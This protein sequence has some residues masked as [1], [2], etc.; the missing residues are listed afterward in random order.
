MYDL[1]SGEQGIENAVISIS[2]IDKTVTTAH[3][4]DF[5]RLL[6]PGVYDITATADG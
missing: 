5:W 3:F 2:G 1:G 6:V 4:G